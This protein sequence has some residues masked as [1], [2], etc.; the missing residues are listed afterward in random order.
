MRK[1]KLTSRSKREAAL[2]WRKKTSIKTC[3]VTNCERPHHCKGFCKLHYGRMRKN[4]T[5]EPLLHQGK[6]KGE[7]CSVKAC[8]NLYY[9]KGL[10]K[11]HYNKQ[12]YFNRVFVLKRDNYTC[13]ECGKKGNTRTLQVHHVVPYSVGKN[14]DVTNL[15]TL[16]TECHQRTHPKV[17]CISYAVS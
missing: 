2:L 6:V 17:F 1:H 15:I 11:T 14:N 7:I 4:G 8:N 13:R 9:A 16:C 5:V 12:R 3:I 10:C